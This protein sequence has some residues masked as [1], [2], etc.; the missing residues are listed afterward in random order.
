[1]P[2]HGVNTRI[3]TNLVGSNDFS[4]SAVPVPISSPIRNEHHEVS[5][6]RN[7]VMRLQIELSTLRT[8]MI[9]QLSA[10]EEPPSYDHLSERSGKFETACREKVDLHVVN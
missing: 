5:A 6:L 9:E 1:M 8:E 2:D 4:S 10:A 7:D 3:A